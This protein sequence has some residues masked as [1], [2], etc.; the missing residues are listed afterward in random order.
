MNIVK[1]IVHPYGSFT[2]MLMRLI[3]KQNVLKA[4]TS[5]VK[6]IIMLVLVRPMESVSGVVR[7]RLSIYLFALG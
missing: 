1:Q 2:H 4:I 6:N 5:E 3:F 7:E